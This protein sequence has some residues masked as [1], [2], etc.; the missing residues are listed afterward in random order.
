MHEAA[1]AAALIR[2]LLSALTLVMWLDTRM[3]ALQSAQTMSSYDVVDY[4]QSSAHEPCA[5]TCF[6]PLGDS[7]PVAQV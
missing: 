5:R 3:M 6:R 4:E 1:C 2:A 7:S